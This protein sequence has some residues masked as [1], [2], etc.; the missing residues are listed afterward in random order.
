MCKFVSNMCTKFRVYCLLGFRF[1][2][3]PMDIF[4]MTRF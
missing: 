3:M 2:I 4:G 1:S